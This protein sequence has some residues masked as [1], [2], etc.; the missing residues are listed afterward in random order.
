MSLDKAVKHGKEHRKPYSGAQAV[1]QSCRNHGGCPYC[2]ENRKH[3]FRDKHPDNRFT[4][5]NV[6][7]KPEELDE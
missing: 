2:L 6:E 4:Q 5:R 3:K 7:I 1:S